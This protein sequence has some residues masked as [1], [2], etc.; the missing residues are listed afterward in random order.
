MI[1]NDS[2]CLGVNRGVGDEV[3]RGVDGQ[4]RISNV[5]PV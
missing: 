3:C 5:E 4:V 2:I 1:I